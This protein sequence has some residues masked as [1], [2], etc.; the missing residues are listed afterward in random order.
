MTTPSTNLLE[1]MT[2]PSRL[3]DVILRVRARAA[4]IA[5]YDKTHDELSRMNARDLADIGLS[6]GMIDDI[7]AMAAEMA[8]DKLHKAG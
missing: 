8:R 1:T 3:R 6:R 5:A 7:A 2:V 4:G